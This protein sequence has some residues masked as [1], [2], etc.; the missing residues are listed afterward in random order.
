VRFFRARF[1]VEFLKKR[2][3]KNNFLGVLS[4][5]QKLCRNTLQLNRISSK[6]ILSDKKAEEE[7][8]YIL[9]LSFPAF[10]VFACVFQKR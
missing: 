6:I 7:R 10:I 5:S 4:E 8:R 3:G 9:R 1:L 2:K